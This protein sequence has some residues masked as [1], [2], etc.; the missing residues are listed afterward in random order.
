MTTK[1][2]SISTTPAAIIAFACAL[3]ASSAAADSKADAAAHMQRAAV[4]YKDGRYQDTLAEL[5]KAFAID[6]QPE[7]HYS[8]GQVYV[9]LGRCG[10]AIRSYERFLASKPSP[11][12]ADLAK[13]AIASCK[14]QPQ[15]QAKQATPAVTSPSSPSSSPSSSRPITKPTTTKPKPPQAQ[16]QRVEAQ[17]SPALAA[18]ATTSSSTT[19]ETTTTNVDAR[20]AWYSDKLGLA[21]TGG[22][23]AVTAIGIVL[24]A[25][26]RGTADDAA[27]AA[28]YG[29]SQRLYDDARSQRTTSV[30]VTAVGLAATG[31]GVWRLLRKRGSEQVEPRGV[32]FVPAT[33]GGLITY[34]G[35]F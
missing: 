12:R 34:S 5:E 18:S 28:D 29:E 23:A 10:D 4:A 13:Q 27:N 3:G 32:A 16:P 9:K 11:D 35:G 31:V 19:T 15:P 14:T 2:A 8:I 6:P 30:I 26:A 22:G 33:D 20:P 1:R 25:R 24:Y 21:L 7:L 17:P